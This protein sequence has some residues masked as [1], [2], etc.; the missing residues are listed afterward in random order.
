[1]A[2]AQ[3]LV[4]IKEEHFGGRF[5]IRISVCDKN[6]I[7]GTLVFMRERVGTSTACTKKKN[8]W[9]KRKISSRLMRNIL[10]VHLKIGISVCDNST[11][12]GALVLM[13]EKVGM[14][15]ACTK[16]T[17]RKSARFRRD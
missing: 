13:R 3:D 12:W 7:W 4:E 17:N 9:Q 10:A 15:T 5:E 8:R 2:K 6:T 11:I 14:S 1:M 16:K